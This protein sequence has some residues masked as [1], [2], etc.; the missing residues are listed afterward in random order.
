[1]T[2]SRNPLIQRCPHCDETLEYT[3]NPPRFCSHCGGPLRP[4]ADD[5]TQPYAPPTTAPHV[6]GEP[7]PPPES[8]G[9]YRLL[10]PLG[11]GGMGTVYEGEDAAT[12]RRV[13]VKLVRAEFADSQDAVERF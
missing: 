5:A 10:R 8:V 3:K 1:M 12:G 4:H 7:V 11:E 2:P 9:G 13:A 6:A